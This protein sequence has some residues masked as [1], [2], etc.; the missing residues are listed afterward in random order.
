MGRSLLVLKLGKLIW[1]KLVVQY[2]FNWE[3]NEQF[4]YKLGTYTLYWIAR[5]KGENPSKG[6]GN[7][8]DISYNVPLNLVGNDFKV[9]VYFTEI[10]SLIGAFQ[11]GRSITFRS[12]C[13]EL[14]V[15]LTRWALRCKVS[16]TYA[17]HLEK[18]YGLSFSEEETW[19]LFTFNTFCPVF[20][21]EFPT[22]ANILRNDFQVKKFKKNIN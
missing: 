7:R 19:V 1:K 17:R 8:V 13:K 2:K 20:R 21:K 6:K 9:S 14:S 3:V 5:E 18:E 11:A 12:I 10:Y 15:P 4:F 22:L 16:T